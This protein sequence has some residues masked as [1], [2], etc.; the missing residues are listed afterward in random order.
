MNHVVNS[1]IGSMMEKKKKKRGLWNSLMTLIYIFPKP[2]YQCFL[3]FTWLFITEEILNSISVLQMLRTTCQLR[4]KGCIPRRSMLNGERWNF[5][6]IC[7]LLPTCHSYLREELPPG[8]RVEL[9]L[10]LLGKG[11]CLHICWCLL[12]NT[13]DLHFS[14][15]SGIGQQSSPLSL[16]FLIL[17]SIFVVGLHSLHP[18]H[19]E[20]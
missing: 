6:L 3:F 9:L 4:A 20:F 2:P 14:V 12:D 15:C 16:L 19:W 7:T 8:M 11:L 13:Q 17:S 5:A 1:F 10:Q 18:S